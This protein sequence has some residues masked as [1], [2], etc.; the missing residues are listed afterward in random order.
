VTRAPY[1]ASRALRPHYFLNRQIY[2]LNTGNKIHSKIGRGK[3]ET[4][5]S[6]WIDN[7]EMMIGLS[8]VS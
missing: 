5:I 1:K 4:S 8:E 7:T 3:K 6:A 2:T